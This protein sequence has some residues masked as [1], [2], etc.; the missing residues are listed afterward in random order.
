MALDSTKPCTVPQHIHITRGHRT[1]SSKSFGDCF[2]FQKTKK[3]PRLRYGQNSQRTSPVPCVTRD[4][5]VIEFLS[6]LDIGR[7]L[8]KIVLDVDIVLPLR[9][10][11]TT[12]Q[13]SQR[14]IPND[15][16]NVNIII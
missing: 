8:R 15:L 11:S 7:S 3:A 2:R 16:K 4:M 1:L 6:F 10:C 14:P 12:E 9:H 13:F 5:L